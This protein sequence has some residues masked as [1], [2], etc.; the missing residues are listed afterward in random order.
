MKNNVKFLRR[1]KE[2]DLTQQELADEL[3]VSRHTII[4]I[5]NGSN[6]TGAMVIKIANFF[7]KD[8]RDIFFLDDVA[9]K[10]QGAV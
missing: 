1:S 6:T 5:E 8:P 10:E 2:F 3:K 4:A 9:H 7:D